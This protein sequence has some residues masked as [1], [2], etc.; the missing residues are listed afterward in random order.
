MRV[1]DLIC[2]EVVDDDLVEDV[3][4]G[5]AQLLVVQTNNATFGLSD[6]SVQQLAMSRLRAVETGRAVVHVS[7][8]GVSA[9]IAPDGTLLE[10][11]VVVQRSGA[12]G[13]AAAADRR[14]PW[15]PGWAPGPEWVLV[16][17]G[18]LG[19]LVGARVRSRARRRGTAEGRDRRTDRAG[20]GEAP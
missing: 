17:G 7:T 14:R 9:M 19:A 12:R 1:G 15:P 13:P 2:F 20:S 18:I 11:L 3:V 10:A 16:A 8:V 4:A 6:E 5:G